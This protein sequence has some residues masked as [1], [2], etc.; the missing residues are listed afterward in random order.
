MNLTTTVSPTTVIVNNTAAYTFVGTGWISGPANLVKTGSGTLEFANSGANDYTGPTD[1]LGGTLR[2]NG[3][4]GYS[5]VNVQAGATLGGTGVISGPVTIGSGGM[6]APGTSIGTLTIYNNLVLSAGSTNVFEVNTDTLECDKVT[7]ISSLTYGGTLVISGTGGGTAYTDGAA[8]PLFSAG[9]YSG[10]FAAIVPE[11]PAPGLYWD[12]S[13]LASDGVLRLAT[14]PPGN[15]LIWT[16]AVGGDMTWTNAANWIRT[17]AAYAGGF[18]SND[19]PTADDTVLFGNTI[20]FTSILGMVNNI[21][22]TSQTVSNYS[23]TAITNNGYHTTLIQPGVTLT[24]NSSQLTANENNVTVQ[25]SV[26]LERTD[27]RHHPWYECQSR[28]R[29]PVGDQS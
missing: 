27:V 21:V 12:T 13:T 19:V 1:V 17:N 14:I 5:V 28:G 8:I 22:D 2:V 16:N 18:A 6:F 9:S 29:R 15:L 20:G 11:F 25:G 3:T 10:T 24:V 7:G 23:Y 26:G 4:L